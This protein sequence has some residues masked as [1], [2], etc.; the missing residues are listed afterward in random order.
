MFSKDDKWK[1]AKKFMKQQ[2]LE[3]NWIETIDYYRSIGGKH[4]AIFVYINKVKYRILEATVDGRV[5]AMDSNND[6]CMLDYDEVNISRKE[7]F[8]I[9]NPKEHEYNLPTDIKKLTYSEQD[10]IKINQ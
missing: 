7:F 10:K 4:V 3:G 8:Y 6:F 1:I 9:E 2:N 5:V